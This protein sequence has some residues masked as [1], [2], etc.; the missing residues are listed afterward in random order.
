MEKRVTISFK[1]VVHETERARLIEFMCMQLDNKTVQV[2]FPKSVTT[3]E[4]NRL[5]M[6]ESI[7]NSA[8]EKYK[9]SNF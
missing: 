9:A 3:L 2:W 7:Y 5:Y 6:D 8:I 1:R 4:Y